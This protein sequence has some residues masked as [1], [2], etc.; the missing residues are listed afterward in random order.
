MSGPAFKQRLAAIVAADAA[1]Y[2]RL[3]AS[4]RTRRGRQRG[5]TGRTMCD[6]RSAS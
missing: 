2:S 6:G 1:D 3:M 5:M 4:R